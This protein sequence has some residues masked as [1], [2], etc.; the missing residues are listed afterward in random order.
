MKNSTYYGL[1]LLLL[2]AFDSSPTLASNPLNW[3]PYEHEGLDSE[4]D[5]DPHEQS[6]EGESSE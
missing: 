2:M 1:S 6:D 4:E 5:S 3:Q